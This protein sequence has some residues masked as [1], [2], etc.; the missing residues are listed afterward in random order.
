M[1]QDAFMVKINNGQPHQPYSIL[2]RTSLLKSGAQFAKI[3][4]SIR[5]TSADYFKF[6]TLR[7]NAPPLRG[8]ASHIAPSPLQTKTVDCAI[9]SIGLG[10]TPPKT[11]AGS[12][13]LLLTNLNLWVAHLKPQHHDKRAYDPSKNSRLKDLDSNFMP[14]MALISKFSTHTPTERERNAILAAIDKMQLTLQT[15]FGQHHSA[16]LTTA[17]GYLEMHPNEKTT[18]AVTK[19]NIFDKQ[20]KERALFLSQHLDLLKIK[21]K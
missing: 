18:E 11:L 20:V 9:R 7:T 6:L 5:H 16:N 1:F 13:H 2:N 15:H 21:I 17:V 8:R 10:L 19:A 3:A 4:I 14:I 12:T